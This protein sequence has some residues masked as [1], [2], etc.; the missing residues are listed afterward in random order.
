MSL[1]LKWIDRIFEKLSLV[2]GQEFLGRWEGIKLADVKSDWA[3]ELAFTAE[4]PEALAY[5]LANLPERPPTV[6]T[7]KRLC[8]ECPRPALEAPQQAATTKASPEVV[9]AELARLGAVLKP[10]QRRPMIDD[11][12]AHRIV[13]KAESGLAVSPTVLAM[14]KSVVDKSALRGVSES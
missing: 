1:P 8:Q 14:A 10:R 3:H 11:S 6:A 12:W 4:R 2:Y 7:F 5:A 13:A 9:A